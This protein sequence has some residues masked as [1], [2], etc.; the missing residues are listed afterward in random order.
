MRKKL[1]VFWSW[2]DFKDVYQTAF[3]HH[4]DYEIELVASLGEKREQ[5]SYPRLFQ[6]RRRVAAREFDL[7]IANSIMRSPYPRN[8]GWATKASHMARYLT[9]QHR[10]LDTWWAPWVAAA[11][12]GETPLAIIDARD[13]HYVY[14]WDWP[15]LKACDL[16][17]KRDLMALLLRAVQPLQDYMGEKRLKPHMD[18]LRPMSLGIQE[19]RMAASSRLM[20]E[21][22][23]DIFMSGGDNLL[24][25][26]IREKCQGLAKRHKVFVNTGL[27]PF[28]EYQEMLQRSKLAICVE[29]WGGETWRQYEVAAAGAVPLMSWPY[30]LVHE[31]L[32]PDRHAIYFSYIGDHF[33]RQVER[34][35]SDPDRLQK[36]SDEARAFVLARKNRRQLVNHV[37]ET[38]LAV[39]GNRA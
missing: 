27:L 38:T 8:K 13:S 19:E 31:P 20:R 21:R 26:M 22:D 14:P 1:L 6:L 28:S 18:K 35:L 15:L 34:A 7:I 36:M 9:Y 23:I 4:P 16:Y 10:R 29:S 12:R 5:A 24:R 30:T 3:L 11:G 32:E 37:V 17:F 33:E 2:S 25:K 39:F